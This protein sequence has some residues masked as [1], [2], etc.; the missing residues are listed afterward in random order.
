MNDIVY[1][2]IM[3]NRSVTETTK[4]GLQNL[5]IF[6]YFYATIEHQR[7]LCQKRKDS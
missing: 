5:I 1:S 6:Y 3:F 7:P 4:Y 2:M